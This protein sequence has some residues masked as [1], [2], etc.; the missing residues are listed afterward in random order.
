MST[1]SNPAEKHTVRLCVRVG[2]D[3]QRT[4]R[5]A[6]PRAVTVQTTHALN[7]HRAA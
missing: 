4:L 7:I 5:R 3:L 6:G 1:I 2:V